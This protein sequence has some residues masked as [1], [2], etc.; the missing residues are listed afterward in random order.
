MTGQ[1]CSNR[2]TY[3]YTLATVNFFTKRDI[4]RKLVHTTGINLTG[5]VSLTLVIGA[6]ARR[7]VST[8]YRARQSRMWPDYVACGFIFL[9]SIILYCT[10]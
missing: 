6:G 2:P 10:N 3:T 4:E 1:T 9:G 7:E 8:N 5:N